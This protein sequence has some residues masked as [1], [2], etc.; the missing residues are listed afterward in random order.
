M[1]NR[2]IFMFA[3]S[4]LKPYVMFFSTK[5]INKLFVQIGLYTFVSQYLILLNFQ[6]RIMHV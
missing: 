5:S 4:L 3:I 2:P 6:P 1:K